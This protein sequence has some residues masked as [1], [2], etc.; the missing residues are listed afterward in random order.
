[1]SSNIYSKSFDVNEF[2]DFWKYEN[3]PNLFWLWSA[4][5][6]IFQYIVSVL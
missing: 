2:F 1:M 6:N 3:K 4:G 5:S